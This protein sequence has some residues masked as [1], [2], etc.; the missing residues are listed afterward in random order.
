MDTWTSAAQQWPNPSAAPRAYLAGIGTRA[1]TI[2]VQHPSAIACDMEQTASYSEG[3]LVSGRD[4]WNG[5]DVHVRMPS[6]CRECLS[7]NRWPRF[8]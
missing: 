7:H 5:D 1:L 6:A 8:A 4:G 2:H 3:C